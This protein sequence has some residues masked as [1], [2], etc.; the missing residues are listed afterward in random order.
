[1]KAAGAGVIRGELRVV[2]DNLPTIAAGLE[3]AV[4]GLIRD[5]LETARDDAKGVVP[6]R[7][8]RLRDSIVV[9][10]IADGWALVA[11]MFYAFLVEFG[12]RLRPAR[13]YLTPA[14]NRALVRIGARMPNVLGRLAR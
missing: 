10:R 9:E 4:N 1:M 14:F 11:G 6:V 13:P 3:P 7:T 5:E 12:T 2:F 8:G